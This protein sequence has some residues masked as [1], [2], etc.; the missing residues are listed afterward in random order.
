MI[1]LRTIGMQHYRVSFI[2]SK[3]RDTPVMGSQQVPSYTP[4]FECVQQIVQLE[5]LD[6]GSIELP[7]GTSFYG[8]G[9]VSG[10]LERT[11]KRDLQ[12]GLPPEEEILLV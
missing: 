3:E 12:P 6:F 8:T 1:V 2:N 10:Q 7:I 4:A 5:E 9:E 11:G